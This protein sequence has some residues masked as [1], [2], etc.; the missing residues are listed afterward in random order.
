MKFTDNT[1]LSKK[2][3]P[4]KKSNSVHFIKMDL[5]TQ[6]MIKINLGVRQTIKIKIKV[7]MYDH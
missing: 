6:K 3:S 2:K 1:C 5:I 4:I 7:I